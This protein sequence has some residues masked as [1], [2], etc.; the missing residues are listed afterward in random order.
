MIA[1]IRSTVIRVS[2]SVK[3][4]EVLARSGGFAVVLGVGVNGV[5]G[6]RSTCGR[7][8][9]DRADVV[10][11]C[12]GVGGLDGLE[13]IEDAGPC[14]DVDIRTAGSNSSVISLGG[15]GKFRISSGCRDPSLDGVPICSIDVVDGLDGNDGGGVSS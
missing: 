5:D 7:D 4:E 11:P 2:S 14:D 6:V 13:V 1:N 10:C 15:G 3:G 9:G 12:V 8:C